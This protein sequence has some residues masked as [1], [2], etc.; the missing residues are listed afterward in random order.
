MLDTALLDA[1]VELVR[2]EEEEHVVF[3]NLTALRLMYHIV[4]LLVDLPLLVVQWSLVIPQLPGTLDPLLPLLSLEILVDHVLAYHGH[5]L[6][7]LLV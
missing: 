1:H 3:V 2:L 4:D 7:V 6:I 5:I